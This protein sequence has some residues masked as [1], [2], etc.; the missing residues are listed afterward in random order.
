MFFVQAN[1]AES[2]IIL[3]QFFR[4]VHFTQMEFVALSEKEMN[5]V[6]H[7]RELLTNKAADSVEEELRP[8]V[9]NEIMTHVRK[10]KDGVDEVITRVE[11]SETEVE[12]SSG[13]TCK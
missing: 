4:L 6:E 1:Y 9:I 13:I 7:F 3:L 5:V 11:S 2:L 8:T 10:L 12:T